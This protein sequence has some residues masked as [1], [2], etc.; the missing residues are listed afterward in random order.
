[1]TTWPLL[2]P[3][4]RQAEIIFLSEWLL[5]SLYSPPLLKNGKS[6]AQKESQIVITPSS[7]STPKNKFVPM[8]MVILL[9]SIPERK[10]SVFVKNYLSI[11]HKLLICL[12]FSN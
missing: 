1:M 4:I 6:I 3:T 9:Q 5:V 11:C 10:L 2:I 8:F 12:N 7:P